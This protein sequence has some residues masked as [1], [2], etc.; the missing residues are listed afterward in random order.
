MKNKISTVT[1][2]ITSF[3]L[4][5][6]HFK[7]SCTFRVVSLYNFSINQYQTMTSA[8][9]S[10]LYKQKYI[11]FQLKQILNLWT[12]EQHTEKPKCTF[13]YLS[14]LQSLWPCLLSDK[15]DEIIIPWWG[16]KNYSH[17]L[18]I[19]HNIW[20]SMHPVESTASSILKNKKK[21]SSPGTFYESYNKVSQ[22]HR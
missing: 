13:P 3:L 18:L 22:S 21:I 1:S 14:C 9:W 17:N 20:W 12:D 15:V 5:N 19:V 16:I 2:V 7:I 8:L 11:S 4:L 10:Q 6:Q